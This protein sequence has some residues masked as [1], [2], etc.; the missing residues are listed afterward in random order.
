MVGQKTFRE[1]CCEKL[2]IPPDAFEEAVLWRCV[3]QKYHFIGRLRW[4]LDRGY[5][6]Y[7]LELIEAV[8]GCVTHDEVQ[9]EISL[10]YS[11]RPNYGFGR[12]LLR[13]RLSG[14]LLADLASKVLPPG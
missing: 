4:R 13:A 3:P 11:T 1:A 14:Q 8:G 7:D 12:G 6:K 10:H 9:E 5:F 2:G